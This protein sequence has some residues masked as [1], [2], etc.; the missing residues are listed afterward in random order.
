MTRRPPMPPDGNIRRAHQRMAPGGRLWSES[1]VRG[2]A[3][4]VVAAGDDPDTQ[5]TAADTL[6]YSSGTPGPGVS[7]VIDW[8]GTLPAVTT[9]CIAHI[10]FTIASVDP[11]CTEIYLDVGSVASDP[12]RYQIITGGPFTIGQEVSTANFNADYLEGFAYGDAAVTSDGPADIDGWPSLTSADGF[13][14]VV[15]A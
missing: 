9:A 7:W 3:V 11:A 10:T 1:P 5:C 13:F 14:C 4:R 2:P 12:N 6:G 8:N 15:S